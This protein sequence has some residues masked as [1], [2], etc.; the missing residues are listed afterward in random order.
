MFQ[1]SISSDEPEAQKDEVI[2]ERAKAG[3]NYL[4]NRAKFWAQQ[5]PIIRPGSRGA[6]GSGGLTRSNTGLDLR[7]KSEERPHRKTFS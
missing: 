2:K 5:A 1:F 7:S 6:P 4:L 3:N